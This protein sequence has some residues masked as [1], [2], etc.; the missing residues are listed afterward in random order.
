MDESFWTVSLSLIIGIS[1]Y[2]LQH[3]YDL[4]LQKRRDQL[5]R[6]NSQLREFYGPVYALVSASRSCFSTFLKHYSP[7]K[8]S[9]TAAVSGLREVIDRNPEGE[10]AQAYRLWMKE[11]LMPFNQRAS[12]LL[13]S[14]AD[15]FDGPTMPNFF[16]EFVAHTASMEIVMRRWEAG[17]FSIHFAQVP[18]PSEIHVFVATE[19]NRL[20]FIQTKL[21]G[22]S[23]NS[24]ELKELEGRISSAV[25]T[26]DTGPVD[27]RK[28]LKKFQET[29][30]AATAAITIA[31]NAGISFHLPPNS[32]KSRS[33]P[34]FSWPSSRER[35]G[36]RRH[37]TPPQSHPD[38]R[39]KGLSVVG[40]DSDSS[41]GGEKGEGES[42]LGENAAVAAADG[43]GEGE[44]GGEVEGETEREGDRP[45]GQNK[46]DRLLS[47][48][49]GGRRISRGST[50][51]S[52]ES[53]PE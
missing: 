31:Q 19:F 36:K 8:T 7:Q 46:L 6:A 3:Y 15:L 45:K 41:T 23:L 28:N 33:F 37:T 24:A 53:L 14:K 49:A 18:Y 12:E 35:D 32:A 47:M 2:F 39:S 40:E 50:M 21:L 52:L 17:D 4:Q 29:V 30:N 34:S 27:P 44:E 43:E 20:K 11:I 1:G 25:K 48:S 5:E 13:V 26:I 42:V 10:E 9:D 22:T 38:I 16:L 51:E